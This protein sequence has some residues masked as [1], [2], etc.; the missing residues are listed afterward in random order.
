VVLLICLWGVYPMGVYRHITFEETQR[1]S[2]G[3]LERRSGKDA[4]Q[5]QGV[6]ERL[7]DGQLNIAL[8]D[9]RTDG[10]T[11]EAGGVVDV[12]FHDEVLAM[13][14]NGL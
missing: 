5:A 9:A 2:T 1:Q 12:Q 10:V 8:D 11:G 6:G 3:Q 7:K 14:L 13:F 4:R